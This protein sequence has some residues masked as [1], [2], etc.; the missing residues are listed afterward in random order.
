LRQSFTLISEKV[1]A[2]GLSMRTEKRFE[3]E[4]ERGTTAAVNILIASAHLIKPTDIV[5]ASNESKNV[6]KHL[7]IRFI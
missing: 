6:M 7:E 2:S 1:A 5:H 4:K 3:D